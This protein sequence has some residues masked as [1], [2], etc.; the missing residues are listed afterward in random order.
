MFHVE[1]IVAG[2]AGMVWAAVA[3][4]DPAVIPGAGIDLN[5]RLYRPSGD[6]PFPAIVMLHGCG[7]L[8]DR[9]GK[10]PIANYRFW[11]EHFQKLGYVAV[12]VDSFGSRGQHEICTQKDR[13]ISVSED[14][15]RDAYAALRWLAARKDVDA[16]RIHV[17]GWSNG[18]MAVLQSLR[19]NAPGRS[20]GGPQFRSGVAFY[21]GCFALAKGGYKPLAPLLIEAGAADD[22]TPARHCE[23]LVRGAD[24]AGAPI[25]ID[26]YEGANHGFDSPVGK[27]HVRPEVRNPSSPTGW[28]ATVG[29]NTEARA[30]AIVRA[31]EF[32]AR[33]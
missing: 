17:M 10:N 25:E 31:T 15:P 16:A 13:T 27:V 33:K 24:K 21:P 14:R 7:G 30:R 2:V 32:L 1:R 12:L 22:W 9:Q 6:G 26:V 28:G 8:W 4:G 29:P 19:P 11:A 5:A 23:A 18:A 20:A 3:A